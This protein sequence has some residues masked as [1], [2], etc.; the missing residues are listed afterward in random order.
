MENWLVSSVEEV[1]ESM[2]TVSSFYATTITFATSATS[3]H[4]SKLSVVLHVTHISQRRRIWNDRCLLVVIVL[5]I[6]TQRMFTNW[7]KRFMKSW[8]HS[9]SHIKTSKN[10]S[11]TRQFSILSLSVSRKTLTSKLRQQYGSGS[12]FLYQFPSHQSWFRN[13]FFSA[14]PILIISSCLLSLLSKE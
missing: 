14:T 11:R 13:P 4:C 6:F 2:K 5:N 8:M 12:M 7:E 9:I 10:C 1:F 3:T